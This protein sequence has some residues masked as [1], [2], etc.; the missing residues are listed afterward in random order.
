MSDFTPHNATARVAIITGGA[1]AIGRAIGA[2]LHM[3][4]HPN[5]LDAEQVLAA[6]IDKFYFP[7]GS[8]R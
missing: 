3:P 4:G 6:A 5:G 8:T 1:G 2:A 7:E